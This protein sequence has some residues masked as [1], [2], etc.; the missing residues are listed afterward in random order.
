V[1]SESDTARSFYFNS[2]KYMNSSKDQNREKTLNEVMKRIAQIENGA[3]PDETFAIL[4]HLQTLF[5]NSKTHRQELDLVNS[6]IK[7]EMRVYWRTKFAKDKKNI[8][9]RLN[10]LLQ[11]M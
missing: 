3:G 9:T 8:V 6:I 11:T 10:Q 1:K 5:T 7:K 2:K 4:N